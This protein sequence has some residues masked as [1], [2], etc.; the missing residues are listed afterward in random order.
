[1]IDGDIGKD[2]PADVLS[3]LQ[4]FRQG[5]L[6]ESPAFAFGI[7]SVPLWGADEDRV[8]LDPTGTNG[9]RVW[10]AHPLDGP[11][12][13][14]ITTQ[15]CDLV[16]QGVPSQPW[17]SICPVYEL[18]PTQADADK[19]LG[20]QYIVKLDGPALGGTWVADL[21]IEVPIEKSFLAGKTPLRGF[22]SERDAERFGV[23]LGAKRARPAFANELADEVIRKIGK[24]R[25][26]NKAKSRPVFDQLQ[27]LRLDVEQG[28][29]LRPRV[30]RL[31][32]ICKQEPT[33]AV[34]AWFAGWEESVRA[35]AHGDGI[36][37]MGSAYHDGRA[38][39]LSTYERSVDLGL[40]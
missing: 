29:N 32:V 18:D 16:E 23:R 25:A 17:F 4:L 34:R 20:K 3:A 40:A 27:A 13:G 36:Q 21:R 10:E 19:L 15:T 1:M 38:M 12:W 28:Y 30:V 31:H 37:L 22:A 39:D 7:G 24:K 35:A 2:W 14:L 11:R 6:V 9:S 5:D 26:N 33:D 8:E